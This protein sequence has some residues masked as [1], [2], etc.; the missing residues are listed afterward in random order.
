MTTD[1][2]Q[3]LAALIRDRTGTDAEL[4]AALSADVTT[5]RPIPLSSLAPLL[6]KFGVMALLRIM[7][8]DADQPIQVRVGLSDFLDQLADGRQQSLDTTDPLIAARAAEMLAAL[9]PTI[10]AQLN[11]IA[12]H[13]ITAIYALGGG[14]RISGPV[15]ADD[16]A[17]ARAYLARHDAIDSLQ[18][19]LD[20]NYSRRHAALQQ[21]QVSDAPIPSIEQLEA[22]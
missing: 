2:L 17:A 22:M 11:G 18:Q 13:V 5:H 10:D 1:Q 15:S 19:A 7:A 4:A 9:K 3:S 12:D 8:T 16:I 14:R 20:S 6:R 21:L